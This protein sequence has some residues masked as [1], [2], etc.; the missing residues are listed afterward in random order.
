MKRV[1]QTLA[2]FLAL[3][4]VVACGGGGVGSGGTGITV[5]GGVGSGGTGISVGPIRGFGSIIVN[6]V[7]YDVDTATQEV[8]D[9]AALG[10]GMVVEVTGSTS[11][12]FSTGTATRVRSAADLRGPATSVDT[13]AGTLQLQGTLVSTDNATVF[14][15]AAD[16][17]GIAPGDPVMVHG[18]PDSAGQWRATRIERLAAAGAPIVTGVISGLN[19]GLNRFNLGTLTIDYATAGFV[20]SLNAGQLADGLRVRVRAAAAPVAGVLTATSVQAWYA[21]GG[22]NGSASTVAG[23]VTDFASLA[24]FKLL[25]QTVDASQAQVTGGPAGSIGNGVLVEV[26]GTVS[27]G[28]LVATRVK[29][30]HVPGSGGPVSYSLSGPVGAFGSAANFRVTGQRVDASGGGVVFS[31]GTVGNL[32]NGVKVQVVGSQVVN[33]VLIADSVTFLP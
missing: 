23:V 15:G 32:G 31:G 16:L 14:V 28:L 20:G 22:G 18:L 30:R 7:T 29:I 26:D 2:A 24:S 27:Q 6:G 4:V 1:L 12:D 33:G 17:T 11:A 10:L 8:D 3:L 5:G 25:G 21:V 9:V 19:A 13:V